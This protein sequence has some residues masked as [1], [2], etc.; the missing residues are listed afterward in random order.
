MTWLSTLS[1]VSVKSLFDCDWR[2]EHARANE[3]RA[4]VLP[5]VLP[6][7]SNALRSV[8]EANVVFEPAPP[9]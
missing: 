1:A 6:P 7:H 5:L 4:F 9:W 3:V 2:A 8:G